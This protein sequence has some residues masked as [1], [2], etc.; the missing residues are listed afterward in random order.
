[1]LSRDKH[2]LL[3]YVLDV[4]GM[5]AVGV[6]APSLDESIVLGVELWGLATT[7]VI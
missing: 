2:G 7:H 6:K 4:D 1:M 3:G 5:R